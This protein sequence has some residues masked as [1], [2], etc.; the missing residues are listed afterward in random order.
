MKGGLIQK[1]RAMQSNR[2]SH[3]VCETSNGGTNGE[4]SRQSNRATVQGRD[5]VKM[6]LRDMQGMMEVQIARLHDLP[7]QFQGRNN[8]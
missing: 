7:Q 4:D 1:Q 8:C 2:T 6:L 5:S 3:F